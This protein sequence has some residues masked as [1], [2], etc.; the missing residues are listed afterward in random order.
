MSGS[1]LRSVLSA[2]L[3][4]SR[5]WLLASATRCLSTLAGRLG[6][7]PASPIPP[8]SRVAA[9]IVRKRRPKMKLTITRMP[10]RTA[11]PIS[12]SLDRLGPMASVEFA[13]AL[14]PC[15]AAI[16]SLDREKRREEQNSLLRRGVASCSSTAVRSVLHPLTALAQHPLADHCEP[17]AAS[18][19]AEQKQRHLRSELAQHRDPPLSGNSMSQLRQL[20]AMQRR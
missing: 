11:L 7:D 13:R 20:E 19:S 1:A 3:F 4:P 14:F 6:I 17:L 5:P 15:K 8:S 10:M 9:K 18:T 2:S 12:A 16:V